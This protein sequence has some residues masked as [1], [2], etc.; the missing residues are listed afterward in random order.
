[1][2]SESTRTTDSRTQQLRSLIDTLVS[3]VERRGGSIK[4]DVAAQEFG[5]MSGVFGPDFY[6]V[7][8]SAVAD[9]RIT[10]SL[11]SGILRLAD[12]A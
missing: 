4:Q 10:A 1:M 5:Q 11:R 8:N 3:V 2:G 7:V 12:G 9:G 6:Y